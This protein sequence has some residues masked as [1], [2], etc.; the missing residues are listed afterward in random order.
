[1]KVLSNLPIRYK[2]LPSINNI[3]QVQNG[4]FYLQHPSVAGSS[5]LQDSNRPFFPNLHFSLPALPLRQDGSNGK[6]QQHWAIIGA[7]GATTFLEILRGTYIC[8]PPNAR[9]FPYLSSDDIEAK[10][11]RLRSPSRAIQYVGFTPEKGQSLGGGIRGSYLS[12]RYESRCEETDWTLLQYLKGETEL[13]PSQDLQWKDASFNA[14]LS[15]VMNDLRLERLSSMPV[16][17]LS[18]GQT[19]RARI[20]KALLGKPEVLLLD[21]PFSAYIM[22]KT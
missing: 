5:T 12:A 8:I 4:T 16:S 7:S 13:N 1:M 3:V 10:D 20:A 2:P 21:E 6:E 19:R 18:N 14:L 15:K 22:Y 11:H 9:T 17:N